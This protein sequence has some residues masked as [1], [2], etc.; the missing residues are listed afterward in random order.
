MVFNHECIVS[1]NVKFQIDDGRD[2]GNVGFGD[3]DRGQYEDECQHA[4]TRIK[5]N[6]YRW[7]VIGGDNIAAIWLV[8]GPR[9]R[10]WSW[11]GSAGD[12]RWSPGGGSGRS[13]RR[14]W[15][16][17]G[18]RWAAIRQQTKLPLYLWLCVD[19]KIRNG[20]ERESHKW[21]RRKRRIAPY[22][23]EMKI[24]KE[25][26]GIKS[27][28]MFPLRARESKLGDT[29]WSVRCAG[30]GWWLP[31]TSARWSYISISIYIYRYTIYLYLAVTARVSCV[32]MVTW[33]A[34]PASSCK[35]WDEPV[36][37][38]PWFWFHLCSS[39]VS[40]VSGTPD[41]KKY[42]GWEY[43]C[44]PIFSKPCSAWGGGTWKGKVPNIHPFTIWYL[45]IGKI[46]SSL[47]W[48]SKL[49]IRNRNQ[50]FMKPW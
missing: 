28:R 16:S 23:V 18:F 22:R 15:R 41:G 19:R 2:G 10:C 36:S 46:F 1:V 7:A 31:S 39:G 32:R 25:Q 11:S 50:I 38:L 37:T 12:G 48:F 47:G 17:W 5:M 40:S 42:P 13:R 34:A 24:W 49:I 26:S 6:Y 45:S 33:S 21:M 3:D 27:R 4:L 43:I 44:H 29:S 30:R 35:L 14:S 8:A 9:T 20:G